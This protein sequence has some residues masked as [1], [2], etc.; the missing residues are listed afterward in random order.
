MLAFGLTRRG[1]SAPGSASVHKSF[2]C[3]FVAFFRGQSNCWIWAQKG[4]P[5]NTRKDAK[6]NRLEGF[7]RIWTSW[8]ENAHP[9]PSPLPQERAG[10]RA[11]HLSSS[12]MTRCAR[13]E[14]RGGNGIL[15]DSRTP[16]YRGPC[17]GLCLAARW[18]SPCSPAGVPPSTAIGRRR[19]PLHRPQTS[20]DAG[21]APGA[22]RRTGTPISYAA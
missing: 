5:L 2:L 4:C 6:G 19:R 22:A 8:L 18:L 10:V 16:I 9:H 11:D 1:G 3:V 14:E 17:N 20:P 7:G 13:R 21:Q 12:T 15:R